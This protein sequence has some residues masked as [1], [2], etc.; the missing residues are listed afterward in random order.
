MPHDML[1][2]TGEPP[3]ASTDG[4][5]PWYRSPHAR[6]FLF[7]RFEIADG[8]YNDALPLARVQELLDAAS[9][10]K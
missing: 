4:G 5:T 10:K 6:R 8:Y 2:C 9:P 7:A 3:R 1:T